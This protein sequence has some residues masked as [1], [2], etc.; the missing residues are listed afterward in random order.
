MRRTFAIPASIA[1]TLATAAQAAGQASRQGGAAGGAGMGSAGVDQLAGFSIVLVTGSTA[2]STP[3]TA[4]AIPPAAAKAIADLK[5]FL[6]YRSYSLLDSQWA[7]GSRGFTTTLQG[8]QG[9]AYS[10][11]ASAAQ[12]SATR[13]NV[14]SFALTEARGAS[15]LETNAEQSEVARERQRQVESQ[16]RAMTAR[17]DAARAKNLE[18]TKAMEEL[19]EQLAELEHRALVAQQ[20][21]SARGAGSPSP[22]A[23]IRTSFSMDVGETVVVGTSRLDGDKALIVLL[24]A[25]RKGGR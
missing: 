9:A 23:I 24:T 7:L 3:T 2:A 18:G 15:G 5:D 4:S 25:V 1:L 14:A 10:V 20:Q 16:L 11:T 21:L 22:H 13:V 6:P 8:P 12:V 17:V 19:K